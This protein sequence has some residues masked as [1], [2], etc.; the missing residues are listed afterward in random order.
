M[1]QTSTY[2]RASS[3]TGSL[4]GAT[5]RLDRSELDRIASHY[6][7]KGLADS[8]HKAYGSAQRRYLAFCRMESEKLV[9]ATESTLCRFVSY[10]ATEKLK[11]RT[12]KSYLSGV[13]YL[14]ISEGE[15]DPFTRPLHSLEYTLRGVK[16]CEAEAGVN[17]RVRLPISPEILRK[18]KTVWEGEVDN[19]DKA[20]LWA[21]CCLGF[22]CFLRA[23][24]MT[25]PND[26]DF[27]PAVHLTKK[28]ITVDN[29][30]AP[31]TLQ[32]RLKQSKTD[33]FRQGIYL[34]V[35]KTGS[36]LCPVSAVLA[37]LAVRGK[38][39]GPLFT[40]HDGR[41]LTCQRLVAE[42]RD[43]LERAG[44]D[45]SRYCGH[46][47]RIGAA[48]TAAERGIEDAIIKTLGRWRSLAYLDYIKI[49]REQLA[50]YSGK[51]C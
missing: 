27:D 19:P 6:F 40:Y 1:G 39:E 32:V 3:N 45:Q 20:M 2:H 10:L 8:T 33:P 44:L 38:K 34:F 21:A 41:Y 26:H 42:V 23:G 12:I 22:F 49:P 18:M 7:I 37:Y 16:R 25:V 43:A 30:T 50:G 17:K 28:D 13:Q 36:D 31:H 9:P 5:A 47:F 4:G 46:S 11:H 35:G 29:Q 48:T 14:H 24:E 15:N 51:L